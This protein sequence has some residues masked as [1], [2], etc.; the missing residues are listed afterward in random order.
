MR[1]NLRTM[2]G[3][4]VPPMLA[5]DWKKPMAITRFLTKWCAIVDS[6][7]TKRMPIASWLKPYVSRD[8]SRW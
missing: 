4:T 8:S 3:S 2:M 7:G 1:V 6:D 5:P